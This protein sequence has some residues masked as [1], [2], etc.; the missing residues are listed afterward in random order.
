MSER[1]CDGETHLGSGVYGI[2]RNVVN[3]I[4]GKSV[5]SAQII[6]A[7]RVAQYHFGYVSRRNGISGGITLIPFPLASICGSCFRL[8]IDTVFLPFIEES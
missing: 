5:V 7:A 8:E 1:H 3:A 2:H 4:F 6:A